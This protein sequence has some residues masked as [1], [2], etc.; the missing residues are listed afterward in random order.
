MV[1]S[2]PDRVSK[3]L[4]PQ[5]FW[6]RFAIRCP[7][8]RGLPRPQGRPLD[9]PDSC[10]LPDLGVLEGQTPWVNVWAG[11]DHAGLG[12]A[13]EVTGKNKPIQTDAYAIGGRDEVEVWLDT[14]DTRDVHRATRFC[15]RFLA[16]FR[17]GVKGPALSVELTQGKIH[18]AQADAPIAPASALTTWAEKT[19]DGHRLEFFFAAGA[20]NGFDPE[21]N[22]RLGLYYRVGDPERGD[23]FLAVGREF[24]VGEDPSMWATLELIDEA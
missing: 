12:L 2:G 9:L 13:F 3:A 11:W 4:I 8:V 21:T 23:R 19:K 17:G 14:R 24:P 6:F 20:L 1:P 10:R 7:R 15:H 16:H 18:R 22:R 5:T